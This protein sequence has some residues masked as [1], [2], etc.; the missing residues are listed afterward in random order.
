MESVFG[1]HAVD[2]VPGAKNAVET[3]L[4]IK[5]GER[6]ALIADEAS[7]EVASSLLD[8]LG[9]AGALCDSVLL[10]HVAARPLARAP[11]EALDPLAAADAGILCVQPREGELGARME[12]VAL[13]E[14]RAIR[15]AHMIGVTRRLSQSGRVES[16]PV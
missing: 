7:A 13:V 11:R 5:P 1:S 2:L 10:E 4:A 3:C 16:A 9:A 6:V 14:Q 15:Y 12:I 8:A